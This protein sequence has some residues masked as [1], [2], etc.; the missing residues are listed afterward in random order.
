[1][2]VEDIDDIA[3]T[4]E[5]IFGDLMAG[6]STPVRARTR[7]NCA[8]WDSLFQLNLVVAIEQEFGLIVPDDDAIELG[9]FTAAVRLVLNERRT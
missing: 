3:V 6:E 2:K 4:M 5:R 1:V 8:G 9:S 7:R